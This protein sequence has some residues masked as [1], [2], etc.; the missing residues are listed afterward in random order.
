MMR[1]SLILCAA[2]VL[3]PASAQAYCTTVNDHGHSGFVCEEGLAPIGIAAAPGFYDTA[4]P[5]P[6]GP[7]PETRQFIEQMIQ[8]NR[9]MN[10]GFQQMRQD[11][12]TMLGH[13]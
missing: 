10:R 13:D 6:T 7:S 1:H 5:M 3:M 4:L 9:A 8:D 11:N 2:L 12:R